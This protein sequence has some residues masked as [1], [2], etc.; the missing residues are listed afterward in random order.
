MHRLSRHNTDQAAAHHD[1]RKENQPDEPPA[2]LH[3]TLEADKLNQFPMSVFSSSSSSRGK[4]E[5]K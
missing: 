5:M 4:E 1:L 2:V 3:I